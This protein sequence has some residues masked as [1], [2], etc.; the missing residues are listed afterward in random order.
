MLEA[1]RR[2]YAKLALGT[3][4]L[5]HPALDELH[6]THMPILE[7]TF[8][9]DP[10][11]GLLTLRLLKAMYVAENPKRAAK[12]LDK[13]HPR[14]RTEADH[15]LY[16]VLRG[17]HHMLLDQLDDMAYWY[18]QAEK[19]GHPFH[20]PHVLL[21]IYSAFDLHQYDDGLA[22]FDKAIDCLY[23]YLPLDEEVQRLIA[24]VQANRAYALTMMQRLQDAEDALARA[25][26]AAEAPEYLRAAALLRAVQGRRDEASEALSALKDDDPE[27]HDKLRDAIPQ[28]LDGTHPHFFAKVPDEGKIRAYWAWFAE[29]EEE[30][31]R[32]IRENGDAWAFQDAAF[33]PLA[34]EENDLMNVTFALDGDRPCVTWAACYSRNYEA[35]I[36]ALIAGCPA[37]I[38][39]RWTISRDP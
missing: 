5:R 37:D 36:T 20:K 34:P 18:Q 19:H 35:L 4:F 10:Y 13:L 2:L 8:E 16:C 17:E 23:G 1:I 12:L 38:A 14:A 30:L 21:G 9:N 25:A 26:S 6:S 7:E 15:A 29:N 31:I 32:I 11:S 27:Q 39:S 22:E 28:I 3:P 24:R 33:M